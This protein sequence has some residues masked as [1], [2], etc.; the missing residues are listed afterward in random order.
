MG[1]LFLGWRVDDVGCEETHFTI[2]IGKSVLLVLQ[3]RETRVIVTRGLDK[4]GYCAEG[5]G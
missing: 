1:Q 5:S 4:K 3:L 2:D